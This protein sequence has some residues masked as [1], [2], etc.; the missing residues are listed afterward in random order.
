MS[1]PTIPRRPDQLD[2][3]VIEPVRAVFRRAIADGSLREDLPLDVLMDL[4][5]GLIKGALDA[6]ASGCRGIEESAAAVT[7][8]FLRGARGA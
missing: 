8:L 2:V 4:F 6:T 5:S 1:T 7:T 3:E